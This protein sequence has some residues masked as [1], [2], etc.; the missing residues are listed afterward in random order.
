MLRYTFPRTTS[1]LSSSMS[2]HTE[3]YHPVTTHPPSNN[4]TDAHTGAPSLLIPRID[5]AN[6]A[7]AGRFISENLGPPGPDTSKLPS[8]RSAVDIEKPLR[9]RTHRVFPANPPI[10]VPFKGQFKRDIRPGRHSLLAQHIVFI[11][12]AKNDPCQ[13][14]D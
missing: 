1:V 12:Q 10:G 14:S 13:R 3:H 5:P 11:L 4:G 6:E 8:R 2:S 7:P 9:W